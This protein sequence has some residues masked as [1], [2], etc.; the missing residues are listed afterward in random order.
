VGLVVGRCF[1]ILMLAIDWAGDPHM[2]RSPFSH[3]LASTEVVCR[4]L[5]SL[6]QVERSLAEGLFAPLLG[7]AATG[8][9]LRPQELPPQPPPGLFPPGRRPR[10]ILLSIRC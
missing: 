7:G 5:D 6:Q 9:L 8:A 3:P 2:G 4:S 10:Y 1:L